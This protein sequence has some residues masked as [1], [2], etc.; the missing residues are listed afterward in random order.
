MKDSVKT[1]TTLR[2]QLVAGTTTHAVDDLATNGIR[3]VRVLSES[4]L[5]STLR[6]AVNRVLRDQLQGLGLTAEQVRILS[7]RS[8]KELHEL[9][10]AGLTSQ[11]AEE[12]TTARVGAHP[13]TIESILAD[14]Q[15]ALQKLLHGETL[16]SSIT[17][18]TSEDL[19][20]LEKRIAQDLG[21]LIDKDWRNE[22]RQIE[23][24]NKRQILLLEQRISKL[25][26]A[27]ESTDRVLAH[28]QQQPGSQVGPG[29]FAAGAA[30]DSDNPLYQKKSQLLQALFQA[31]LK[32]RELD[33]ERPTDG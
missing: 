32:L 20:T 30:L 4:Q 25:V 14:E 15:L 24:S 2:A 13:S 5:S 6:L 23:D 33:K 12:T 28:L 26:R 8:E 21:S 10:A 22:L 19:M 3:K 18:N 1:S 31:N 29:Q 7:D 16:S 11:N 27:L 17:K 9:L